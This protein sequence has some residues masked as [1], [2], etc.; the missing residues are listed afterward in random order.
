MKLLAAIVIFLACCVSPAIY[1]SE[2]VTAS[3]ITAAYKELSTLRDNDSALLKGGDGV[4]VVDAN[5]SSE[6]ESLD[7]ILSVNDSPIYSVADLYSKISTNDKT[8]GRYK[9][10]YQREG[11]I[12]KDVMV[13]SDFSVILSDMLPGEV[14]Q[15]I[16]DAQ[17]ESQQDEMKA[18]YTMIDE[19][20][21]GRPIRTPNNTKS[22][23]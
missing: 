22:I 10:I 21:R 20:L 14:S 16:A 7:L 1:G 11:E 23:K 13:A 5:N 9:V 6:F 12:K 19:Y 3:D 18:K 4:F 15:I 17:Q 2:S 8:G